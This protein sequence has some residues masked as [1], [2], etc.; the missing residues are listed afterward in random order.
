MSERICV[1]RGNIAN[2][3]H[4]PISV[5]GNRGLTIKGKVVGFHPTPDQFFVKNWTK[6]FFSQK[7]FMLLYQGF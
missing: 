4:P 6:N 7:H 5:S 1:G 3:K 2:N